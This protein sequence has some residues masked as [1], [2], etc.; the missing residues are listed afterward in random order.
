MEEESKVEYNQ[1]REENK[2]KDNKYFVIYTILFFAI[3][4][5]IIFLFVLHL[6]NII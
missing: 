6:I 2:K 1:I 3:L 4:F 5:T